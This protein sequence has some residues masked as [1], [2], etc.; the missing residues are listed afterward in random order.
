MKSVT[1]REFLDEWP[2]TEELLHQE[3]ELVVMKD[4]R[5]VAKLLPLDE[6]KEGRG[7]FDFNKHFALMD[8]ILEESPGLAEPYD[9]E[10]QASREERHLE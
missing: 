9:G 2:K 1:L 8:E 10:L 6:D 5:P 3:G 4:S 7:S